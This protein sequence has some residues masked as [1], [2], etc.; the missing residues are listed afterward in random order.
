MFSVL[1]LFF[2][3]EGRWFW[4]GLNKRDPEHPGS[5][6]WSDGSPVSTQRCSLSIHKPWIIRGH[7]SRLF[8][9]CLCF[10]QVVTSFID[11]KNEEDDRRDCAVYSDLTNALTPQPC[12]TKHEWICMLPRGKHPHTT[13][14]HTD[15]LHIRTSA[16]HY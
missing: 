6:Q 1:L 8:L 3:T 2:R 16:L 13:S 5:W 4:V 12:D 9:V 10:G 7:P 15:M 14:L 11:D